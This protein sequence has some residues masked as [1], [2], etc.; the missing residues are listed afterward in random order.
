M[1]NS[2]KI[3]ALVLAMVMI[4]ALTASALA[5]TN[6]TT[7]V[8][9]RVT[10]KGV[11]NKPTAT[12][13][14]ATETTTL[15]TAKAV[16]ITSGIAKDNVY[17]LVNTLDYLHLDCG[18]DPVWKTVALTDSSGNPTG[19][20]GQVLV[21][22]SNRETKASTSEYP[23]ITLNTWAST[24]KTV[25]TY[26]DGV[27]TGYNCV[28]TGYDWIYKVNGTQIEDKYMDQYILSNGDLVELV[29]QYNSEAWN[30]FITG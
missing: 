15:C 13:P 30:E 29:Y 11:I 28:Y 9:V 23:N 7:G 1:K 26:T 24:G 16:T 6:A 22:L 2:K 12:D 3:V 25:K 19:G 20:T 4:F 14:N 5:A 18:Y 8:T 17:D 21:S 27:F 10:I